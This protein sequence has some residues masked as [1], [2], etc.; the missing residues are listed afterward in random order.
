MPPRS[1]VPRHGQ[2]IIRHH[3]LTLTNGRSGQIGVQLPLAGADIRSW[4]FSG[5]GIAMRVDD[6]S[7][8]IDNLS[9]SRTW[10]FHQDLL[11]WL[12]Q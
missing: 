10:R 9:L 3:V 1:P 5:F 8:R 7:Y 12:S 2:L 11:T 4:R 6:T